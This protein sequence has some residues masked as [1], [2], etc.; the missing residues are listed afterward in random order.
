M[1]NNKTQFQQSSA[2]VF[3]SYD[4]KSSRHA[5]YT[6]VTTH[7]NCIPGWLN[8]SGGRFCWLGFFDGALM[9]FSADF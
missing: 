4:N 5:Q 3:F 6:P 2:Y 7:N 1:D 9:N 8:I